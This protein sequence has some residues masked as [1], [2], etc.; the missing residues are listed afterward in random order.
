MKRTI[1]N[2]TQLNLLEQILA[3][4]GPVVTF[5]QIADLLP[6]MTVAAKRQFVYRL[7]QAGWLVRIKKGMTLHRLQI[8]SMRAVTGSFPGNMNM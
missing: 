2:Q 7:V 4:I 1:L 6:G 5:E 3:A 8:F